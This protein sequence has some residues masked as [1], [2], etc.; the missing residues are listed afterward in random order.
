L[1][2]PAQQ[3]FNPGSGG[4]TGTQTIK[5]DRRYDHAGRLVNYFFNLNS[6]GQHLAEYNYNRF[7]EL[8]ERNHHANFTAGSWAWMQSTDYAYNNM[9]WLTRINSN[10]HTGSTLAFPSG[11]GC[12]PTLPAPGAV[13]RNYYPENND[14]FYLELRYDQLFANNTAGGDIGGMSG[15]IQKAGNISQ[16]AWRIRGRERQSYS[17]SY[18]HLS[19]LSTATYYDVNGSN[20]ATNT[21]LFN[22]SL[23]Y[24]LRGNIA[25]LQ[26]QGF[27][28]STC[29]YGQI[30]NLSYTYT[31]NTN[32]ISSIADNALLSQRSH[33]FNP[34][35]GGAGYT[36]DLNGNLKT[37]SYKG[38]TNIN[39]NQFNLP[40]TITFSSG[41]SIEYKYD[42]TGNKSYKTV[43][44][45]STTQYEHYYLPGGIEY[46]KTG[47][48]N[49]RI[50]AI[51]HGEGRYFNT[52]VDASDSPTWQ[53]EYTLKDHLGNARIT[54]TDKNGNGMVD[55]PSDIVQENHYYPFG[56]NYEG[57]WRM[58]DPGRDNKY[59]YNGKE[60]N[61]DFGLNW[62]DYGAR[63]YMADIGRWGQVDPLADIYYL[64]S[65]Y[66]YT[67]NNPVRFIDPDGN[68]A[69]PPIDY[70]DNNG[71][72][73]GNDG[74]KDDNRNF[75]VTNK[76][77]ARSIK[78]TDK[79]GG[80]TQLS[81]LSSAEAL[82]STGALEESLNVLKRTQDNGGLKEESSLV[83]KNGEVVIGKT[84]ELPSIV[85]GV[86]TA[87]TVI[88]S[89]PTGST[90]N[91]VDAMIHS[92]PTTT[93]VVG[94]QVYPQTAST[95]TYPQDVLAFGR[96]Q[97][98]IIVGRLGKLAMWD[99]KTGDTRPLGAAIFVK[100]NNKQ[101]EL[102]EGA[103]RKIIKNENK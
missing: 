28:S 32:Q 44:V 68:F 62:Y 1:C 81:N 15:T 102:T 65:P 84:G 94:D 59:Q 30:D 74:N 93:Q 19:R 42:A 6:Q 96:F 58:N 83:M 22:E 86:Q 47:T 10:S 40:T 97:T 11:G 2:Q 66:N 64:Y 72:Y 99:S 34:G 73:L 82:P 54:F 25:T 63:W 33:G 69:S 46:R 45:G 57:A 24:D 3:G 101:L 27:Y 76:D 98:N 89:L 85:D 61:D 23:T 78:K 18:D 41:N 5:H 16:L 51:Y 87:E 95:P 9:G 92:H 77:E 26:R 103:I 21:N 53:K 20:T 36:Y 8:V 100:G 43:K 67:L 52:N 60:L 56:Y 50:E 91:D 14:L 70:Y 4:S 38:I 80:T 71:N 37:D 49:T 13:T 55:V 31:P 88:P 7:D 79:A 17:F 75:V 12:S 90:D 35:A 39:Y 48:G 29:N